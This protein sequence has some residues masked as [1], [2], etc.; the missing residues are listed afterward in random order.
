M[1]PTSPWNIQV[2]KNKSYTIQGE[3]VQDNS[4]KKL[5]SLFLD[6]L[7]GGKPRSLVSTSKTSIVSREVD[8]DDKPPTTSIFSLNYS[9][10][11]EASFNSL[12]NTVTILG[13]PPN[14]WKQVKEIA[15]KLDKIV[16]FKKPL[17]ENGNWMVVTFISGVGV[18]RMLDFDGKLIDD[19]WVLSVKVG[20][21]I[22]IFML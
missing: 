2:K 15:E 4:T 7:G 13:F 19:S 5:P 14:K 8:E 17:G 21:S 11:K 16:D 12:S 20:V 18:S 6:A 9:P 3:V 22:S 1:D 10:V